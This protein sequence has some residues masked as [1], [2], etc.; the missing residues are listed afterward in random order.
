MEP[1]INAASKLAYQG[2]NQEE[3]LKAKMEN[4]FKSNEW[5]TFLQA[6]N[7]GL[8]IKK[9]EHST[10]SVFRGFGKFNKKDINGKTTEETG[11]LGFSKVFNLNQTEKI[12][13]NK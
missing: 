8:R 1:Q 5:L 6:K 7:L 10:A 3:L 9:G 4:N 11:P 12:E 2:K 13:E